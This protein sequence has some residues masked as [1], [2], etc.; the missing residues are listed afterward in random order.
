M[1]ILK[2]CLIP[3]RERSWGLCWRSWA[4]L[5]AYVGGLGCTL[6]ARG[7][8]VGDLGPL[9]GLYSR[10][11]AA[12]GAAVC[13]PGPLL[14]ATLAVLGGLRPLLGPLLA[15]RPLWALQA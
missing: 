13:G 12:L 15:L 11:W 8:Y 3:K 5:G 1:T 14:E 7:A 9:F 10:S 4:A 2:M 6:A